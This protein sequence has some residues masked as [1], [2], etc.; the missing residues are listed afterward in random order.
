MIFEVNVK[1]T[2]TYMD[3]TGGFD[4]N[5][6]DFLYYDKGKEERKAF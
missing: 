3:S 2:E 4:D 6:E 1:H 5:P